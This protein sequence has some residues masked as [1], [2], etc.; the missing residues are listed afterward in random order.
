MIAIGIILFCCIGVYFLSLIIGTFFP[1]RLI[2]VIM[3]V[4]AG[5]VILGL[6]FGLAASFTHD[7]LFISK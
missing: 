6:V 4:S 7:L 2:T 3:A 1:C 5:L